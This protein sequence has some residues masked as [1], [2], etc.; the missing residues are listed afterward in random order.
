VFED[1]ADGLKPFPH[2]SKLY[3]S[4]VHTTS[5]DITKYDSESKESI[6]LRKSIS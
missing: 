1:A 6:E 3:L 2:L 5:C 4:D